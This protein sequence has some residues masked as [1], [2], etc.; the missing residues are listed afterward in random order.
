MNIKTIRKE[1]QNEISYTKSQ[2][3]A[4]E[5]FLDL[6]KKSNHDKE[7]NKSLLTKFKSTYP[8]YSGSYE[9]E[10]NYRIYE[11]SSTDQSRGLRI[12]IDK[13]IDVMAQ[14]SDIQKWVKNHI[15]NKKF[16]IQLLITDRDR[17]EDL[18]NIES[19]IVFLKKMY[20]ESSNLVTKYFPNIFE[21]VK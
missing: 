13:K 8:K 19:H 10:S 21:S 18:F 9:N 4:L 20:C 1:I 15:E 17:L 6:V 3:K 2:V 7:P 12:S 11:I 5:A 16:E 14:W